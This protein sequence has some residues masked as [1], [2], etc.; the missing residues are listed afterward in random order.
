MYKKEKKEI[1]L[2]AKRLYEKESKLNTLSKA[3]S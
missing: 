1:I 2:W 3:V